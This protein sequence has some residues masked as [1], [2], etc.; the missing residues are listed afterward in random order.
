MSA[1]TQEDERNARIDRL[2]EFLAATQAQLSTSMEAHAA[3]MA[4]Y[5]KRFEEHSK[6]LEEHSKRLEEHSAKFEDHSA[7]IGQLADLVLRIGRIVERQEGKMDE[8]FARLTESQLRTDERL[9]VLITTWE[10]Y[11]SNGRN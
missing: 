11:F 3:E 8:G 1:M 6:R 7:K 2:L 10:R 9:N 4:E 5:S